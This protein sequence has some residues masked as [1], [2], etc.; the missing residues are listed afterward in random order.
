M[1]TKIVTI[2]SEIGITSQNALEPAATS[3]NMISSVAYATEL[4]L[5]LEK[6]DRALTLGRRSSSSSSLASGL[7]NRSRRAPTTSR[8]LGPVGALAAGRAVS[9]P[10]PAYRK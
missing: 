9:R 4:R 2:S 5:S 1:I 10:G 6:V 3:V 7:P 8:S